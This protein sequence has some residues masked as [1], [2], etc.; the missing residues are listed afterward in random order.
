[1]NI[2]VVKDLSWDNYA[3]ISKRINTKYISPENRI[4]CF[5][6]K[7]LKPM[8]TICNQNMLTLV[9]QQI[10]KQNIKE[11]VFILGLGNW[12]ANNVVAR[13]DKMEKNGKTM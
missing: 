12:E 10:D 6:G 1:M 4:N 5:Y 9:R 11:T 2:L 3:L 7:N 13:Y 8:E